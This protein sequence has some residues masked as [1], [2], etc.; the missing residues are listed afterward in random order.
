MYF[1]EDAIKS[2]AA[3]YEAMKG[4]RLKL[5]EAYL[6]RTYEVSRA[7]EFAEHGVSRRLRTMAHCIKKVFTI[8]PPECADKPSID[9]LID[10]VVYI[11]AFIFNTLHAS[12]ISRGSGFARKN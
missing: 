6:S 9:E 1:A 11:Q 5:V 3:D 12:T 2:L 10:A 7:K 4:K 8:L